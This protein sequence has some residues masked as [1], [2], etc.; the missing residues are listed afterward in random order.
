MILDPN[1]DGS[2]DI[3]GGILAARSLLLSIVKMGLPVG[4][5]VLDPIIPQYI[6]EFFI[7]AN[8]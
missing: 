6:D 8:N 4:C 7:R 3:G 2:Y 5:E 1:M